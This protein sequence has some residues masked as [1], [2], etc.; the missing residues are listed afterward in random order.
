MFGLRRLTG[1]IV[2]T[3]AIIILLKRREW[4]SDSFYALVGLVVLLKEQMQNA[5]A[6]LK[7]KAAA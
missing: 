1:I 6:A 2:L 4:V 5:I 3:I 7:V